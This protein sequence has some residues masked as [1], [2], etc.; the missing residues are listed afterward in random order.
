[1]FLAGAA[2]PGW[3]CQDS[4]LRGGLMNLE[5][6]GMDQGTLRQRVDCGSW[7][8]EKGGEAR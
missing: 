1:M 7:E 6:Q 8:Q 5:E 4:G 3:D 2:R